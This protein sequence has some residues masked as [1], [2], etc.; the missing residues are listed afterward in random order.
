[1]RAE[2]ETALQLGDSGL[3]LVV[4]ERWRG[5]QRV[6]ARSN[7]PIFAG[8]HRNRHTVMNEHLP[9]F[10]A[11]TLACG[12]AQPALGQSTLMVIEGAAANDRLGYAVSGAGDVDRDG[13]DDMIVGAPWESSSG[14]ATVISGASGLAIHSF[15]G[16][17]GGSHFG[18]SVSGAGDVDGDG[19]DDLIVGAPYQDG[20]QSDAGSAYVYSG[21]TGLLLHSFS[22]SGLRE[23]FG[24]SVSGAGDVNNDGFDDVIVGA[25]GDSTMAGGAGRAVVFSG[26]DGTQLFA[27]FGGAEGD[28][29]GTS[30]S[31]LGDI[32]GDGFDDVL[33]GAPQFFYGAGYAQ[34]IS[35]MTGQPLRTLSGLAYNDNFG[36]SVSGTGDV[37][38]DGLSDV[39]IGAF[40]D[41][42][43]SAGVYSSALGVLVH[44]LEGGSALDF[45]LS[46]GGAGDVDGDGIEDVIVGARLA[47]TAN[48]LQSG[49]A[50]CFSGASGLELFTVIGQAVGDQLGRSV[51]GA[52]DVNG[53]GFADVIIGSPQAN[54]GGADA[55]RAVVVTDRDLTGSI[56]INYCGPGIPNSSGQGGEISALGSAFVFDDNVRLIASQLSQESF[57]IFL[58]S[59]TQDFVAQPTNSV[60]ILCLG[61]AIGR[62]LAPGQVL[63]SGPSATFELQLEL[64]ETPT[65]SGFAPVL[66]GETWNFQAWHRDVSGGSATSNFTNA[67][68][69]TF[70]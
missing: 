31:D 53:D 9:S 8:L 15:P 41:G 20:V 70:R 21:A 50:H 55:G 22:G 26:V 52:G 19:F 32:D 57:G 6:Q 54:G 14:A 49:S 62:Y 7:G 43:G 28:R 10:L 17:S 29:M 64:A 18:T 3:Q 47:Q 1:M 56:G 30:V 34:M 2:G 40:G 5:E 23:H 61:G 45:G 12:V 33:V 68:S 11:I 44:A 66:R 24:Q 48:G 13:F 60:G 63:F 4:R 38:G 46:V 42:T 58:T 65:A 36:Y 67:V 37:D 16:H 25:Y 51:D 27:V 39:V 69:V 35:G 59:Q